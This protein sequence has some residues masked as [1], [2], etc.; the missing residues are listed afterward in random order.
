MLLFFSV[1]YKLQAKYGDICLEGVK[2]SESGLWQSSVCVN[3][4]TRIFHT[5]K[6]STCTVITVQLQKKQ[7]I[8]SELSQK[9]ICSNFT[10]DSMYG[11][12]LYDLCNKNC[13]FKSPVIPKL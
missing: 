5:E 10:H 7:N 11:A 8:K 12:F 3:A 1:G 13:H 9:K 4:Q 2:S 6:D